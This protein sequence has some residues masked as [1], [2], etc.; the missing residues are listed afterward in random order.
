MEVLFVNHRAYFRVN[1]PVFWAVL[2]AFFLYGNIS[3]AASIFTSEVNRLIDEDY[4]QVVEKGYG[5][6]VLPASMHNIT[7]ADIP[8]EAIFVAKKLQD[9]GFT[10]YFVGGSVRDALMEKRVNDWDITTDASYT[11]CQQ[12]FGDDFLLHYVGDTAYGAVKVA[13]AKDPVDVATYGKIPAAYLGHKGIPNDTAR[14]LFNDSFR[15]DLTYNAL[16]YD[17]K[18]GDV[19]DYHGGLHD[20]REHITD[21]ICEPTIQFPDNPSVCIRALRFTARFGFSMSPRLQSAMENASQ[22]IKMIPMNERYYN[23]ARFFT[24][25]YALRSYELLDSY[26]LMPLFL[27]GLDPATNTPDDMAA[28][29]KYLKALMSELDRTDFSGMSADEKQAYV[30]ARMLCPAVE[31]L[32][33]TMTTESAISTVIA[34]QNEIML[35]SD[36]DQRLMAAYLGRLLAK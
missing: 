21:S 15:R 22:Y 25:G 3:L 17:P 28:Y 27:A 30:Y 2:L 23:M 26:N 1:L 31:K 36:N 4:R 18:T 8:E 12:I 34:G 32:Q 13:G 9:A 5:N 11:D 20:M 10:A 19:M 14:S 33:Q 29:K 6:L 35:L 24:G 16:L 7:E